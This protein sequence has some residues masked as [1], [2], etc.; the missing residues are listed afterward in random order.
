MPTI[1][2]FSEPPKRRKTSEKRTESAAK[3][4]VIRSLLSN[5]ETLVT[6]NNDDSSEFFDN[7]A[8]EEEPFL[9][10]TGSKD[11][12]IQT[13]S[14]S[15]KTKSVKTQCSEPIPCNTCS[16]K[17]TPI[18]ITRRIPFGTHSKSCNT[19]LSFPPNINVVMMAEEV[20][21]AST[22]DFDLSQL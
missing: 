12:S 1:F 13:I 20:P 14:T 18:K 21:R 17:P 19:E 2:C 3:S 6:T 15:V 16:K 8:N 11:I 4:E 9:Y 7:F 5:N 22:P 10:N